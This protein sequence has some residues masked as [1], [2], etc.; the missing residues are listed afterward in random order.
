MTSA[1]GCTG[2]PPANTTFF[3]APSGSC[4]NYVSTTATFNNSRD[5]CVASKG[6]LAVFSSLEEQQMVQNNI[7]AYS[8]L[9]A[10]W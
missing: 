9:A 10:D 7:K 8:S 6:W 4:Y 5:S 3:C 2:M 1:L